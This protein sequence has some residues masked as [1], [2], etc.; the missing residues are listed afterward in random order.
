MPGHD[1]G[2]MA[3]P[4]VGEGTGLQQ[5]LV[6]GDRAVLRVWPRWLWGDGGEHLRGYLVVF[7]IM[8]VGVMVSAARCGDQEQRFQSLAHLCLNPTDGY[9]LKD[10]LELSLQQW[11][12]GGWEMWRV[13]NTQGVSQS[14]CATP[15]LTPT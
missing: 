9:H 4:L 1:S 8:K 13:S 2:N 3:R 7:G 14:I 10:G 5:E 12:L 6:P 15:T 11:S